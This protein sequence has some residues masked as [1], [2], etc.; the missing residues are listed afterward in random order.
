MLTADVIDSSRA[1]LPRQSGFADV[2]GVRIAYDVFGD[3]EDTLLLLPPW[4]INHSRFWKGQVPYLARHF[5]VVT[6]DP[7]GNGGSD[8]PQ[9][10]DLYGPRMLERDAIAVLDAAGVQDCVMVVHCG[11]AAAGLLICTHQRERIRGAI[12]MSPALPLTPP[13]PDRVGHSFDADLPA[14]DG[15]AKANRHHWARDYRDYLEFFFAE[16]FSEP[17]ST[18][19]IEDAVDWALETDGETLAHTID[20]AGV[21]DDEIFDMLERVK[22]P[23]LV[24]QGDEDH[25][26]PADRSAEFARITGAELITYE[27]SGHAPNGRQPVR[28]NH[29]VRDFADRVF[30][31][32]A[33]PSRWRRALTRQRRALYVSSPIGLGHAWR[34]VAIARELRKLHPDLQIDWLA[35]DPVTRVLEACGET[36]HPASALLA[37]ESRHVTAESNGHELNAFQA[38][39][40]MDEILLANFMVFDDLVRDEPYDLWIGDEAWELDFFLHENPELKRAAYC[41]LT[42]FVGWIPLPAGGED[43]ARLTADYNA[44]MIEQIARFPRVRDRAIFVGQPEDVVPLTFGEGLPAIRPWVE[45]HFDF[46]G[47]VLAPGAGV[48]A[49]R[50]PL[51]IV[52]VGGSGV[53]GGFLQRVIDAAP[54]LG[55]LRM[56]VVCGPRI[57][58]AS[59]SAPDGVEVVPYVHELS[60]R[61][62]S[63]SVAITQGGLTT[64]MELAAAKTPFVYAPLARHFEQNVHVRHRL[65]RYGA[66]R[67]IDLATSTP[68]SIAAAI[69]GAVDQPPP[70]DVERDGAARAAA[71]ISELL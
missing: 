51:C 34:D 2:D 25:L 30:H 8:R 71:L 50:E 28:F 5:R 53:G 10:P 33:P 44:E 63:C 65:E 26:V 46:S 23:L 58:P 11:S 12:F 37:N 54:L 21:P 40:R 4:A 24:M 1:L 20:C 61:L 45:E 48:A 52:T 56:L 6:F 39:R 14:Y 31:R 7:R 69:T 35:Q 18:K 17:H 55:D 13:V 32:P 70:A 42:D 22:L 41:F 36:V 64:C 47:Y 3:G 66:G 19:Q 43:E 9:T 16:V 68:E 38:V 59:L 62:G 49:E 15:W 57:D 27:G 67:A 60:Q 29:M